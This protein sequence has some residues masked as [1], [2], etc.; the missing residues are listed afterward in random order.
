[1]R[2]NLT[3]GRLPDKH[4]PMQHNPASRNHMAVEWVR[5]GERDAA[6]TVLEEEL[7]RGPATGE[8]WRDVQRIAAQIGEIEIGLEAARRF[9][10]TEPVRLE[11]VLHYCRELAEQ[12]RVEEAL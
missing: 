9:S 10:L 11:R 3:C 7:R 1:N 4:R 6:A 8:G 2:R 5:R 12:G